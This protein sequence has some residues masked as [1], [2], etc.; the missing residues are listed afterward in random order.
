MERDY[1]TIYDRGESA[2]MQI[3]LTGLERHNRQVA[4]RVSG[5]LE[6]VCARRP[7]SPYLTSPIPTVS[8]RPPNSSRAR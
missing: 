6:V 4:E 8:T 5:R 1:L 7:P 2:G 3:G